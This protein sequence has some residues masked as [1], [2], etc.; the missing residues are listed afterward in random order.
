L[1]KTKQSNDKFNF[2]L[3]NVEQ[4]PQGENKETDSL[5]GCVTFYGKPISP[6]GPC[7]TCWIQHVCKAVFEGNKKC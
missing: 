5:P 4:N 1:E 2:P 3:E 6:N 7:R